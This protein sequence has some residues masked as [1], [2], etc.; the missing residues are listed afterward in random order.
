MI[1]LI[2]YFFSLSL[3]GL[4]I[5]N[6]K[7]RFFINFFIGITASSFLYYFFPTLL[8]EERF[9]SSVKYFYLVL[10]IYFIYKHEDSYKKKIYYFLSNLFFASSVYILLLIL[11]RLDF[12]ITTVDSFRFYLLENVFVA[13][14]FDFWPAFNN[15][16]FIYIIFINSKLILNDNNLHFM[17]V[18]N[19]LALLMFISY[20]KRAFKNINL[21][22]LLITSCFIFFN[23]VFINFF[24]Y[25]NWTFLFSIV[26]AI[27]L[28][29]SSKKIL[30]KNEKSFLL[31][32]LT[33][34]RIEAIAYYLIIIYLYRRNDKFYSHYYYL[35]SFY[36]LNFINNIRFGNVQNF[37]SSFANNTRIELFIESFSEL[38]ILILV[39]ILLTYFLSNDNLIKLIE[40]YFIG[41]FLFNVIVIALI[42]PNYF[43]NTFNTFINLFFTTNFGI[44][45]GIVSAAYFFNKFYYKSQLIYNFNFFITTILFL[46]I[47]FR[48][49]NHQFIGSAMGDNI[50]D[51]VFRIFFVL[52]PIS[53]TLLINEFSLL[54]LKIIK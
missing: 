16:S 9:V 15:S 45:I 30:S 44:S 13:K 40:K 17:T 19:F 7:N 52:Q 34:L 31:I 2:T 43:L 28:V 25:L 51:S 8:Y 14:T 24:F 42:Y 11:I 21:Y 1:D 39:S 46:T 47:L 10:A 5:N 37:I 32:L 36:F 18:L 22:L 26:L 48:G 38:V 29:D 53:V 20:N 35:T 27:L 3:I 49:I 41:F 6:F 33:L 50:F 4:V 23:H 12:Q 54:N